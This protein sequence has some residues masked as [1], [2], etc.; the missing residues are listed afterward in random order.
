MRPR[1]YGSTD[2]Y[3]ARTRISPGPGSG[4]AVSISL[5]S[6]SFGIPD[7]RAASVTCLFDCGILSQLQF[8]HVFA[9]HFIGSV[10]QPQRA[11]VGPGGSESEILRYA[12]AA[13]NLN[14]A[15]EHAQRQVGSHHFD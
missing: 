15:V 6:D 4:T 7:G 1:M 8:G 11:T 10:S 9:M 2:T 14:G 5:K 13:M 3:S 12:G